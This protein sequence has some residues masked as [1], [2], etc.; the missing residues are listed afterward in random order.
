MNK[1]REK[2]EVFVNTTGLY[3]TLVST[4]SQGMIHAVVDGAPHSNGKMWSLHLL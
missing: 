4:D 3:K 2:S 1:L